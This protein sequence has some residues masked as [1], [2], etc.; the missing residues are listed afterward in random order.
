MAEMR[1]FETGATRDQDA[2]KL[3]YE[4]FLSPLVLEAY[5]RYMHRHRR[6]ADGE[7]RASD[8]WQK[9]IPS[10]AYMKSLLRHVMD[11][12]KIHRGHKVIDA[13]DGHEVTAIEAECAILFNTMGDMHELLSRPLPT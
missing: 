11:R 12:W 10:V 5:A 9:G 13:T 4:G 3:D 2:D 1:T 8:N 6:Q 7:L